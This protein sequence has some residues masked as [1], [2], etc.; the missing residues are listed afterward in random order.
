MKLLH[1]SLGFPPYRTGGMIKFCIDLMKQQIIDGHQVALMWPG[2]MGFISKKV[3]IK[4]R[5]NAV[6]DGVSSN[7]HS[8]EVIN[9]L[10]VSYD[11]G[12][13]QF[14]AFMKNDGRQ[15]YSELLDTYKPDVIHVHTLMGLHKSFLE[16]AKDKK[17]QLVFTTHD[18]F[19]VCPKVTMFW[20]GGVC[21]NIQSC[22]E[23]GFCNVTALGMN[24]IWMLQ[25]H[26]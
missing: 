22:S 21:S 18:F 15:V 1:Y 5:G 8:F 25:S 24:K 2:K 26:M 19:P 12:I 16:V 23:C 17:I 14:S 4:N 3:S 9:P 11:E 10:P 13:K 6:L 7:I 20:H